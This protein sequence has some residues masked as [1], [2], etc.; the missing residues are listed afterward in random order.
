M[1]NSTRSCPGVRPGVGRNIRC[2]FGFWVG[3]ARSRCSPLF[4]ESP[5]VAMYPPLKATTTGDSAAAKGAK[6]QARGLY[7]R[8]AE[9][10][11][12]SVGVDSEEGA[13]AAL[14]AGALA[15]ELGVTR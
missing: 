13:R 3:V 10:F 9:L 12:E 11:V 5:V 4:A 15:V 8:A 14:R 1:K 7:A 2:S 6:E